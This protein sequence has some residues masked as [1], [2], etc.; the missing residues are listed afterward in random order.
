MTINKLGV[1]SVGK[2]MGAV[3]GLMGLIFGA[4]V[5]LVSLAGASI[6]TVED[7]SPMFGALFGVG[8]VI[9][10]PLLYGCFGFI[11]GLLT[12]AIYNLVAGWCGGVEIETQ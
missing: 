5:A 3:Y 7:A 10:L 2:V 9:F 8:A 12:A 6:G 1:M 11:G 4:I